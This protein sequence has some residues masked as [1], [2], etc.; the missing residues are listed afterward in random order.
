MRGETHPMGRPP[1]GETR[2]LD[3]NCP[4]CGTKFRVKASQ[5][6]G[7]N[8]CSPSCGRSH[9]MGGNEARF[10]SKVTKG[11]NEGDCWIWTSSNIRGYG[12]FSVKGK[13]ISAHRY[14]FQIA[15]GQIPDG[16]VV[17]HSCDNP[18]CVNP[19]HL[20]AGAPKDNTQDML[21]KGRNPDFRGEN[22]PV[23]KLTVA[24]VAI[25]KERLS[26][27]LTQAAIAKEFGVCRAQIWRIKAGKNWGVL[28]N[29]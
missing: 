19:D 2:S 17:M 4:I 9:R 20:S 21:A 22:S 5:H 1:V 6:N 14:S 8:T 25:I 12:R 11:Q 16:L 24:Q 10:W 18:S 13:H 3:L 28:G 27:G 26:C 23:R 15:H 7:H 29:G